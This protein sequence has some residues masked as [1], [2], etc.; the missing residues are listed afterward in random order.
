MNRVTRSISRSVVPGRRLRLTLAAAV[1]GAAGVAL[2]TGSA[3]RDVLA[4]PAVISPQSLRGAMSG[5]ASK[6]GR[7]LAVG[8]RGI[9]LLS[10]DA[11]R[12]W[13]QLVV[14][15]SA[16]LTTVRFGGGQH[17]M[18]TRTRCSRPAFG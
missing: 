13:S 16:D 7:A 4:V 14:P 18:G 9:I 1:L 11:G 3:V 8:P 6:D 17:H 10:R 12:N 15:V 2:A 5:I